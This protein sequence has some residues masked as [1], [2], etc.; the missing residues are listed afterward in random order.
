MSGA[1]IRRAI[2]V[3]VAAWSLLTAL[4][5]AIFGATL[6]NA[7]AYDAV[8]RPASL[9][10]LFLA[11]AVFLAV[12]AAG[13]LRERE[14]AWY[15]GFAAAGASLLFGIHGASQRSWGPAAFDVVYAGVLVGTLLWSRKAGQADLRKELGP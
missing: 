11:F 8:D 3:G 13:L 10:V 5:F 1:G 4:V 12:F 7:R 14:W 2:L 6:L 15:A 9:G